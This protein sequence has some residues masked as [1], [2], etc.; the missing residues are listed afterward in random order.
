MAQRFCES[1]SFSSSGMIVFPL[2]DQNM[3]TTIYTYSPVFTDDIF[4]E[5]RAC[6]LDHNIYTN[7]RLASLP[8][9]TVFGSFVHDRSLYLA[10]FNKNHIAEISMLTGNLI[11]T[12]NVSS[13]NDVCADE[14]H[15][16]VAGGTKILGMNYPTLGKIYKIDKRTH[17]VSVFMSGFTT[18]SGIRKY[19]NSLIVSRLYDII[20]INLSTKAITVISDCVS[21]GINYLSD[22]ITIV[23]D[24]IYVSL[25]RKMENDEVLKLKVVPSIGYFMGTVF[26]QL[27]Q[28]FSGR[29]PNLSN[30]EQLLSFSTTDR[31][32]CISY[33]IID[34]DQSNASSDYS[35]ENSNEDLNLVNVEFRHLN[36]LKQCDGH[37]TQICEFDKYILGANFALPGLVLIKKKLLEDNT[38]N[39]TVFP[40][41]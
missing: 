40:T 12:Y 3:T 13:P 23:D 22:N 37:V 26:T 34:H 7:R 38:V 33:V 8:D 25:Y 1:F 14:T 41:I 11:R 28:C 5:D 27:V 39:R 21:E 18:L 24:K 17:K 6:I 15:I 10:C 31:M 4:G 16:Y 30:P 36:K 35:F 19:G 9:T 2:Q 32:D 29:V 20:S